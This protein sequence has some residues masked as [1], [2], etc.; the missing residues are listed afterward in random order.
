MSSSALVSVY[1][2]SKY[3]SYACVFMTIDHKS[4]DVQHIFSS[5]HALSPL[6]TKSLV[7]GKRRNRSMGENMGNINP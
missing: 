5:S 7:N 3:S 4:A 1:I 2:Q 6:I